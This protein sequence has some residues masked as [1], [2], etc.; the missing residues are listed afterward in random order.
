MEQSSACRKPTALQK[1]EAVVRKGLYQRGNIAKYVF[2][3][4]K[5]SSS[6][7]L[8]AVEMARRFSQLQSNVLIIGDTGTGKEMFAQSIHNAS[9]RCN[10]PFVAVN[11]GAIPAN[12]IESELFGYDEGAFSGARK[13]G[14]PGLFELA[15]GGTI[16]LDEVSEMD[17]AG[18]V[19][20][21]RALQE[22][23]IRRVGGH[24][25]IPIDVR[26]IA[27]C[28]I[29]LYDVVRDNKFRKDL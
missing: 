28:N 10:K 29:N 13:G 24:D 7:L 19:S 21:L 4:I 22:Q 26:V 2:D 1:M 15:H 5:G 14:R 3:D 12:L 23:Q 16:F 20:L 25:I 9:H 8:E 11:C 6:E 27:A 18:Q 17:Q